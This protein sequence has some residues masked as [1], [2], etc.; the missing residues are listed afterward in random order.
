VAVFGEERIFFGSDWP[1]PMGIL[2]PQAAL[3]EVADGLRRR[4]LTDNPSRLSSRFA[5]EPL[6]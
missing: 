1:F 2:S 5:C 6:A 4:I 3:A